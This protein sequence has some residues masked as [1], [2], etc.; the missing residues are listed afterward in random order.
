ME[1]E[2]EMQ[3]KTYEF[4]GRLALVLFSQDIRMSYTA[5]MQVLVDNDIEVYGNERGMAAGIAAAYRRWEEI[6][7]DRKIATTCGAI[8]HTF[9]NKEGYPAWY[10]Y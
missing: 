9:V 2:P 4:I 8:A 10:N 7:K 1:K 5:L 3:N 6:E